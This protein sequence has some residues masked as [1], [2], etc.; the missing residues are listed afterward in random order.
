M[1]TQPATSPSPL[2]NEI[3]VYAEP[4]PNPET[5]K[6]VSNRFLAEGG[7]YD[8]PNVEATTTAPLARTLFDFPYVRGVFIS[9]NYVTISKAPAED[10]DE[11]IP[12]LKDFVKNYLDSG[13]EIV[14]SGMQ[15]NDAATDDSENVAKIKQ[16][17]RDYVQ[18]AIEQDG[19]AIQFKSFEAGRVTVMLQGSC[20]GCPSSTIT[21]KA[22]IE[23]LLKRMVPEVQ[24]VVA[25]AY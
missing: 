18:P 6:F 15:A 7:A 24:E 1:N 14:S 13:L 16:V 22:G 23:G 21:L 5:M 25:D 20:S 9:N 10:W 12:V 8:Y 17:L 4:T 11:L 19:G 3:T 2:Q